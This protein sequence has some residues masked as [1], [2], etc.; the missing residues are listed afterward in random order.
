MVDELSGRIKANYSLAAL[1]GDLDRD[2]RDVT[3][4]SIEAYR[5]YAEGIRLHER[6]REEEAVPHFQRAVELDPGFAMALAKLGVVHGN[7]GMQE[8]ADEYAEAALERLDRLSERE[9]HYIEGWYYSRKPE[10]LERAV[11]AYRK[12]IQLYPDHGSARHNLGNLFVAMESYDDAIEQLEQLRDR[13][14]LFPA[15]YENLAMAYKA[16][17]EPG[18]ARAVLAEYGSRHPDDWTTVIALAELLVE[19]GEIEDGLDELDRAEALGASL[20]RTAPVRWKAHILH[21]DWDD[22]AETALSML[23]SDAPM[24][25][26]FG[27]RLAGVT[28]L[29]RGNY[30]SVAE[31]IDDF[32]ATL[33]P[34]LRSRPLLF[35]ARIL[36]DAGDN[37][38]ARE[39]A[40]SLDFD[41]DLDLD[42]D[43][44]ERSSQQA[45][46][47]AAIASARLGDDDRAHGLA[48]HIA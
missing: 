22:A 31:G 27:G 42:K 9:R 8:E 38:A 47:V 30:H 32:V 10:T 6:F 16:R 43:E 13:G 40:L 37:Q 1:E 20:F 48:T 15:T 12:A 34:K 41:L 17:G 19:S 21:E 14:M 18:R 23:D 35:K 24:E 46:L 11:K 36:L 25:R 39:V 3:T 29:Y 26:F 45:L 28:A 33:D 44:S 5:H 7:L 2:L 4:A